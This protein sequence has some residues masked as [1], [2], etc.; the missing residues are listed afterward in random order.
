MQTAMQAFVAAPT[1]AMAS[2]PKARKSV[3]VSCSQ[4]GELDF[5]FIS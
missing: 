1:R 3:V 5:I 4:Q 2:Q